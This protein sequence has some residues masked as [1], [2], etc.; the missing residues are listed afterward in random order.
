MMKIGIL[1]Y[2]QSHFTY[3]QKHNYGA[4]L[5]A[6]ALKE[7]IKTIDNVAEVEVIDYKPIADFNI[8]YNRYFY[9]LKDSKS[10]LIKIKTF[11]LLLFLFPKTY[12]RRKGFRRFII[13]NLNLSKKKYS[14]IE[15]DY[16][17]DAYV[18]GSDQIWNKGILGE[19]DPILFG[20]FLVKEHAKKISYA[21]SSSVRNIEEEDA[22]FFREKLSKLNS[23]SVRE[24][25][26]ET[27]LQPLTNKK[28]TTVLD[29]TMLA[30]PKL[31]HNIAKKP[32]IKSKYVL[33]YLLVADSPQIEKAAAKIAKC[34]DAEVVFITFN[35]K[36][37]NNKNV[38]QTATPEEFLGWFKHAE[39][40]LTNSFHGTS[41]SIVFNRPF[42]SF[43]YNNQ[44]DERVL[45]ILS[46]LQITDRAVLTSDE[47]INKFNASMNWGEIETRLNI[48]R[49]KS[50]NFLTNALNGLN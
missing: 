50:L 9:R 3:V 24:K 49:E 25:S 21:A 29:P 27:L 34:I 32:N 26:F 13:S 30:N 44:R 39:Y 14:K 28:I 41:F 40:I 18:F 15:S 22:A 23:I 16:E 19:F 46:T 48:E 20:D 7:T 33:A 45:N 12:L 36:W 10:L 5:Q 17:Y 37:K 2:Q 6:Y 35:N 1:T 11:F 4:I 43:L 31:W 8:K 42:F 47:A 38:I